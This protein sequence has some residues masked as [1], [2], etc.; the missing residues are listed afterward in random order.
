LEDLEDL[1]DVED[2]EDFLLDDIDGH[3]WKEPGRITVSIP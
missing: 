1:E 3:F 2:V